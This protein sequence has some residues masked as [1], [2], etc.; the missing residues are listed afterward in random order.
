MSHTRRWS[1]AR[2][3][4]TVHCVCTM[5]VPPSLVSRS[6]S[7]VRVSLFV[8]PPLTG[9]LLAHTL[10]PLDLNHS[11]HHQQPAWSVMLKGKLSVL[12]PRVPSA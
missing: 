7:D 6:P 9:P 2:V 3:L 10:P 11:L 12:R 1:G 5:A 4:S 8:N